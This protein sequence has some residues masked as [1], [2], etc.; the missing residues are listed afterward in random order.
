MKKYDISWLYGKKLNKSITK[1]VQTKLNKYFPKDYV[2]CVLLN[3]GGY[4]IPGAFNV[5]GKMEI[6]NNL[7]SLDTNKQYNLLSIY[8]KFKDKLPKDII[9]FGRDPFGDMICFDYRISSIPSIVF[10]RVE[11]GKSE[12]S[13]DFVCDTF[14]DLL[15]SLYRVEDELI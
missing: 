13:I 11:K 7:Y 9:P 15:S 14:S 3:D 4:P 12:E 5:K 8:E 10:W 2:K 6:L 1:D